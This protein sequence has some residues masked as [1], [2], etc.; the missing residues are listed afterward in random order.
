MRKNLAN[1]IL[2]TALVVLPFLCKANSAFSSFE[3]FQPFQGEVNANGINVRS[4]STVSSETICILN[5]GDRVEVI[6]E[7][8]EWYKIRLPKSSPSYIK[9]SFL[10]CINY[11]TVEPLT[12]GQAPAQKECVSAKLL[13]D[14]VNVRLH[15]NTSS[16][17]LGVIDKNETVNILAEEGEW[18]K[19]EP[20]VNS[21]GYVN[22]GFVNKVAAIEIGK[23]PLKKEEAKGSVNIV[24]LSGENISIIGI[25]KPYGSI[26]RRRATHKLI[27]Q[28]NKIFLLKGD[29]KSLEVLCNKKAKV[30]GKIINAPGQEYPVIEVR[31]SEAVN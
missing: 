28:E 22:K 12:S 21:F 6:S 8:Y 19:I 30:T 13:R 17:I 15:P 10:E 23:E 25:I 4:D 7:F 24:P 27:T 20:I 14:R 29:K 11:K 5:K 16:K 2:L 26:F 9:K 1:L 18:C 31:I 3:V